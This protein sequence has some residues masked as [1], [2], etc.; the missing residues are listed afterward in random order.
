MIGVG[1]TVG[2]SETM[3]AWVVSQP[4]PIESSP[5]RYVEK[6]VPAPAPG[7]LLVQVLACAVCR[8]DPRRMGS[9]RRR[10]SAHPHNQV[11]Q[12]RHH[13]A[14]PAGQQPDSGPPGLQVRGDGDQVDHHDRHQYYVGHARA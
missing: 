3:Q 5:L 10:G 8:T 4:G 7:E 6:P 12:H 11:P 1:M 14:V 13:L 2:S 9:A